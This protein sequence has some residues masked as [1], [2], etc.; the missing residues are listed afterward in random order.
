MHID[1]QTLI[2]QFNK[3]RHWYLLLGI[4]LVALGTLAVMFSYTATIVS[5]IYLAFFLL[6]FGGIEI[7]Q[8]FKM[9]L[10]NKFF[11][12]LLPGALYIATG[13]FMLWQPAL[14]A[15][16]LTLLLACFFAVSGIAKIIFALKYNPP[17]RGWII[18][19]GTITLL[20][21]IMIW[22]QWPA[23]GLWTIGLFVGIDALLTGWS[24]IILSLTLK[25]KSQLS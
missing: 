1:N 16:T 3:N 5:V 8:A 21:G 9:Q 14:N 2:T 6:T 25:N 4:G 7:F 11:L 12:H 17:H 13:A 15:I 10:W 23:S 18:F 19:N 24:W 20:L 22:Y